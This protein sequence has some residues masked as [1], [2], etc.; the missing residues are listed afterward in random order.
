[1]T[2]QENIVDVPQV[3]MVEVVRRKVPRINVETVDGG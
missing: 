1:V 2:H 3:E